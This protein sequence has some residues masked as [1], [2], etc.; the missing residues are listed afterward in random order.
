[1]FNYVSNFFKKKQVSLGMTRHA[2]KVTQGGMRGRNADLHG[3][4]N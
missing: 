2:S 1:M 4:R 3:F